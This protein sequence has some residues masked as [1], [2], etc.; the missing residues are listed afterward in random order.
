MNDAP[1]LRAADIGVVLGSG[2]DVAHEIADMVLLDNNLSSIGAAVRE[3]RTIFDNIRKMMVF[4]M[5]RSFSEIVMIFGAILC[6][7]PLPLFATQIFWIN[8]VGHGF[9]HL[10]LIKEPEEQDIMK[11][12][13]RA[14]I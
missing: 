3:G 4:L 2:S 8:M 10:A 13:P 6:G 9:T 11:R 14:K 7:Y 12:V 1:A 5:S